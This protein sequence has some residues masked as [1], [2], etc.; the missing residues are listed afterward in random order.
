M[1]IADMALPVR[2]NA[3]AQLN[4]NAGDG[5]CSVR[6]TLPLPV[7]RAQYRTR[8]ELDRA[9]Y[10]PGETVY[11]R[12]L[13]V[14]RYGL[15]AAGT[16]PLEF[17]ILDAKGSPLPDSLW[18]GL[19]NH[20]V[21]NGSFPLP[22]SLAAGTY[23]LP[24]PA[25]RTTRC[26]NSDWLLRSPGPASS[27]TAG[28]R[29]GAKKP[30]DKKA[31]KIDFYPE[32]GTLAAGL[33]NRVYFSAHD[34]Q[35]RPLDLRGKRR[36]RQRQTSGEVGNLRR[37]PGEFSFVP[38][39]ADS[40]RVK[41][42]EPAGIEASHRCRRRRPPRRSRSPSNLRFCAAGAAGTFPP[43]GEGEHPDCRGRVRRRSADRPAIAV[44]AIGEGGQGHGGD[45]STR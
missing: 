40:Y 34:A 20:G 24:R 10:R 32:G 27:Q 8:L 21:G 12:S 15:A 22:V 19:T 36:R 6:M 11:Y 43:R 31:V 45:D 29:T 23:L 38:D 25:V 9:S 16:L 5:N 44:H 37:R 41:I 42:A 18:A 33:E 1:T 28:K 2:P 3:T 35:R 7:R 13:T 39:A 26:R 17:E 4:V 30:G 14:S